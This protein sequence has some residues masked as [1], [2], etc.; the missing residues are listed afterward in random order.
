ML[1]R[2]RSRLTAAPPVPAHTLTL[3][4]HGQTASSARSAYSGRS[5]IALTD[6]GREQALRVAR[7]LAGAGVDAVVAQGWEAG[8]HVW[9]EVSTLALVPRVV[10]A[11]A[12]LPVVAAGGIADGRGLAAVLLLGAEGAWIGTRFVASREGS[13][14]AWVKSRSCAPRPTTPS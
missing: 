14:A 1:G 2:A 10:D 9:G 6:T 5:D 4:R 11:V 13:I 12:P 8:G 3:V 7:E